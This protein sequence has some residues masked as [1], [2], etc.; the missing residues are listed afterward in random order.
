MKYLRVGT[1]VLYACA[2]S[3]DLAVAGTTPPDNPVPGP[4]YTEHYRVR[5]DSNGTIYD[6][7][8]SEQVRSTLTSDQTYPLYYS[9]PGWQLESLAPD[10]YA[11]NHDGAQV[12]YYV[13]SPF[14]SIDN[15]N[16]WHV[17][18]CLNKVCYGDTDYWVHCAL[19]S[20]NPGDMGVISIGSQGED[21]F[22]SINLPPNNRCDF[23]FLPNPY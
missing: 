20:H 14:K 23:H 21:N 2:G 19:N 18:Y 3:V 22:V 11:P 17:H 6:L 12:S 13:H 15:D 7:Q 4:D 9:D 8:V 5:N 16:L 1:F 10:L